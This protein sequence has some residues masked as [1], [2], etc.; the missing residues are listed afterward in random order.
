ME[1]MSLLTQDLQYRLP[2][3][4]EKRWEALR[5]QKDDA[6][7]AIE[8]LTVIENDNEENPPAS[9]DNI[10]DWFAVRY[11]QS[12]RRWEWAKPC[13]NAKK[14]YPL[15]YESLELEAFK[16]RV[17][18]RV[19]KLFGDKAKPPALAPPPASSVITATA[20]SASTIL[21]TESSTPAASGSPST[22]SPA[23][24]S[25]LRPS[26]SVPSSNL[27][28]EPPKKKRK[29]AL[30]CNSCKA[31]GKICNGAQKGCERQCPYCSSNKRTCDGKELRCEK[32]VTA[33]DGNILSLFGPAS[34]AKSS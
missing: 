25:S 30:R 32:R 19:T 29:V 27:R 16:K 1:L 18:R 22:L 3:T 11:Q 21:P 20:A 23:P 9:K 34:S 12:G 7:A 4:L 26:A 2:K 17:Y 10:V 5:K 33:K 28:L 8:A 24:A 14:W 31:K 15:E 13:A 6:E